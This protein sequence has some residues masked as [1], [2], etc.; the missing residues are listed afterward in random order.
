MEQFNSE[1]QMQAACSLW[2][3]NYYQD[4]RG[5][6]IAVNNNSE[7]NRLGAIRKHMG[8]REGVSDTIYFRTGKAYLIELKL[9]NGSQSPAQKRFE[10]RIKKEGFEYRIAW[11]FNEFQTI[12]NEIG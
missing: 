6:L 10:K 4:S 7:D 3:R 1:A 9:P 8:I 2:F 11:T 12:I 5:V